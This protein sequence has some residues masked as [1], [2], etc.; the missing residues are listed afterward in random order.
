MKFSLTETPID[1]MA[2]RKELLSLSAGGYCSY[3]GWVRDHNEGKT[4][5]RTSTI[6]A[7]PS[8]HRR[9]RK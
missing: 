4:R 3:E 1:P 7:T 6:L 8:S 9:S 2:L 5:Q